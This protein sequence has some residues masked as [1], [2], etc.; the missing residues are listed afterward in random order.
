MNARLIQEQIPLDSQVKFVLQGGEDISGK[1]VEIG[2]EHLKIE[3]GENQSPVTIPIDRVSYWQPLTDTSQNGQNGKPVLSPKASVNS[4]PSKPSDE[5]LSDG[6]ATEEK[7][8][9]TDRVENLGDSALSGAKIELEKKLVEI[10]TRFQAKCQSAKIELK[11]PDFK[12]PEKELGN[13]SKR[14]ASKIWN[15]IQNTYQNAKRIN[16]LSKKFGR[17]QPIIID[18]KNLANSFRSSASIKRHLAYLYT[19]SGNQQDALRWYRETAIYS[20]HETDWYNLAVVAREAANEELA[21]YSLGQ[22]FQ[23]LPLTNEQEAW[24]LYVH[25]L[26]K[27]NGHKELDLLYQ[28]EISL[29]SETAVYLLKMAGQE[30]TAREI[31]RKSIT[32]EISIS[33]IQKTLNALDW[34]PTEGYQRVAKKIEDLMKAPQD[35]EDQPQQDHSPKDKSYRRSSFIHR[36]K[37]TG[38]FE[39]SQDTNKTIQ[40][41]YELA[42]RAANDGDYG[43]AISHIRQVLG[44]NKNYPNALENY[45]KWREYERVRGVPKGANPFARAKRAQLVEKD[46]EKA[47]NFFRQAITQNDNLESAVNDLAAL[48][49]QLDRCQDAVKV[50]EQ[51]RSRIQ[52]KK[53]L[54]NVL[55]NIYI[56][57]D[58]HV[59]AIALLKKQLKLA[60][61]KEK[62]DQIKWQIAISYVKKEEYVK[63]EELFRDILKSQPDRVSAKHNLALC[64]SRQGRYGEAEVLLNQI[65][66]ISSDEKTAEL[67]AAVLRAKQTGGRELLD[68]VVIETEL[69]DYSSGQISAFTQFFL[70]RCDFTGVP[71]ER[72]QSERFWR[73]DIVTL[74]HRATQ[75]K[76]YRPSERARYYLSAAKIISILEDEAP[77]RFYRDLCRSFASRGDDTIINNGHLDT[78]REWYAEA[79][80]V[81]DGD[82]ERNN[83]IRDELDAVNA[84]VRFLYARLGRTHIPMPP[85]T[86]SIDNTINEVISLADSQGIFDDIRYLVFRSKYAANRLLIRLYDQQD[87]RKKA[88]QYLRDKDVYKTDSDLSRGN[89]ISLWDQLIDRLASDTRNLNN[90]LRHFNNFQLTTAWLEHAIEQSKSIVDK[91]RFD[92]DQ[93]RIRHLQEMLEQVVELC[94]QNQ[95]EVQERL[96][97]RID[98]SCRDLLSEVEKSPTRIS[99]EM[100]YPVVENIQTEISKYLKELYA[101]AKPELTLSMPVEDYSAH[102]ADIEIEIVI[103]NKLGCSPAEG[104]ELIIEPDNALFTLVQSKIELNES[105]LGG[106]PSNFTVKLQ[107]TNQALQSETFSL[108]AHVRYRTSAK[109]TE[110]TDTTNFTIR[111]YSVDAF[112]TIINPYNEGPVVS[113]PKM[114]YGRDRMIENIA[115]S[116]R[117]SHTQNKCV[118]I[119]GQKRAGKSSIMYHLERKLNERNILILDLGNIGGHLDENSDVPFSYRIFWSILSLLE[120]AIEDRVDTGASSLGIS[121]PSETDF[122]KHPTPLILFK[123]VFAK[124]QYLASKQA[125]WRDIQLVLFIDEFSYIYGQILSGHI[126]ESFMKNWKALM[127]ANYF[128]AV[129]VGQD[130]MERFIENFQNEFGIAQ[131][132][133]VT[134]LDKEDAEK[135]IDEPIRIGGLQGES[136]YRERH[137]ID[138]IIELT[139]G[140]PF[141]IQMLCNRLVE[142]LNLKRAV[143]ITYSYVEQ[144]KNELMSGRN[145][146]GKS[147]FE[148]LYNSGENNQSKDDDVLNILQAIAVHSQTGP[149]NRSHIDCKTQLPVD[150]LLNEL[151]TRD[152]IDRKGSY[153]TIKVGLFK[154]WLLIHRAGETR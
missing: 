86:P 89:F 151:V 40:D 28:A 17:I 45:E 132:E 92:L 69:S 7:P 95:F 84:L 90:D 22:V 29:L 97:Q 114:F 76:S 100:L 129:L 117:E 96:C 65:S 23:R 27:F 82:R 130:V 152:V 125:D 4:Q 75:S 139:A 70:D 80:K 15:R 142:H 31:L 73:S 107:L 116:L 119:Y 149:C 54:E 9:T 137:A 33:S 14:D 150:H 24:Y 43:K 141:Y 25:L 113:D 123:E 62:K 10:E 59:E 99:V 39:E 72:V 74:E 93:E 35:T 105:L 6:L 57:A 56:K 18:L 98:H 118:V 20:R 50:I 87:L 94:K 61:S 145:A 122:Y 79:L 48:L 71:P 2:R 67:L 144:V 138:R 85:H 46:L 101:K 81:Y 3:V 103:E 47:E 38:Y 148:N 102:Q 78:A 44:I 128:N 133:R 49:S 36:Q 110:R 131:T 83:N 135:L 16:E 37:K 5:V 91:L 42:E 34:Q 55:T 136:R 146:L 1:L 127:Q 63:P 126:S 12:F 104:L 143:Y 106:R 124:Y 19:V 121:F 109:A 115:N 147:N 153:Y 134:Y 13:K 60:S 140:S 53:S 77:D 26:L 112:E 41:W 88:L 68:E 66:A 52:N 8:E 111:L 51:N 154:E 108:S 30:T 11:E 58:M 64:L 32:G 120:G 21:C